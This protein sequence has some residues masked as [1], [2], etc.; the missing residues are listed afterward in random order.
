MSVARQE[1]V[2]SECLPTCSAGVT[3][4]RDAWQKSLIELEQPES[5]QALLRR[6]DDPRP[7][8]S[9][10]AGSASRKLTVLRIQPVGRLLSTL[11]ESVQAI[12]STGESS[13]IV[14]IATLKVAVDRPN[15]PAS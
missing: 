13:R 10:D 2:P 5:P 8:N 11:V 3:L 6:A 1:Q 12:D 15:L 4:E 7:I 9:R 14:Q